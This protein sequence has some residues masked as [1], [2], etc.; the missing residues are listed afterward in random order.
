MTRLPCAHGA[1]RR[2]PVRR[3]FTTLP[4]LYATP[5]FYGLQLTVGAFDPIQLQG[6]WSRTKWVR[7]ESELTLEQ[8]FSS[9]GKVVLFAKGAAQK[10]YK[11]DP[12]TDGSARRRHC[13]VGNHARVLERRRPGARR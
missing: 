6:A 3:W 11:E 8:E 5:V 12:P 10:L 2:P 4:D 1:E 7:P 13:L 9:L